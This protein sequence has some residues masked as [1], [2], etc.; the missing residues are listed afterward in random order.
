MCLHVIRV[1]RNV[2]DLLNKLIVHL[3]CPQLQSSR[4]LGDGGEGE[5]ELFSAAQGNI[6]VDQLS[7]LDPLLLF[8]CGDHRQDFLGDEERN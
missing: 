7:L 5:K 1:S 3:E 2:S 6:R 8:L 4:Q